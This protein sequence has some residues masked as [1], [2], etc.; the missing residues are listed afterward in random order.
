MGLSI[1]LVICSGLAHAVWNLLAKSSEDKAVFLWGIY[2]PSTV[3]LLPVFIG[4]AARS[5]FT[6]QDIG[7][8]LLSLL[9]QGFYSFMLSWTYKKGD[10][11]QV[12]PIMR[13][14]ST[15]LIPLVG[16]L[17]LGER[18][19]FW[20]WCG[21]ACMIAGFLT[22]GGRFGQKAEGGQQG[23]N[24]PVWLALSVG[25]IITC[26]TLADKWNLQILSP[27][28]LLE[29]TN[30]GF[31]LGLTPSVMKH[32]NLRSALFTRWHT[33]MPGWVL[34][35]GSYLLFLFAVQHVQVA[36]IAPLRE[37]GIVF[38]TILGLTVLKENFPVRR[39]LASGAVLT[40]I[41]L[42]ASFGHG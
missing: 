38:G 37:I 13:G 27:L 32:A 20:G 18:L 24:K 1:L 8:L 26:Y 5:V 9:L 30:I 19:P 12:Y 6:K 23:G 35:P 11:S 14:T 31:V 29:V 15:L 16:V 22:M 41:G 34:S 40:G 10:L 17:F 28:A 33:L 39:L 36:S 2:M 4:E 42:I 3:V 25:L 7:M 21:I